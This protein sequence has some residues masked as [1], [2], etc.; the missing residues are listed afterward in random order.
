MVIMK[1]VTLMVCTLKKKGASVSEIPAV[2]HL[3]K[4]TGGI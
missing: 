1:V 3:F 4:L 2:W